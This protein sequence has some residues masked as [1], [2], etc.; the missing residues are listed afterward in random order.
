M[1]KFIF[2]KYLCVPMRFEKVDT[3]RMKSDD[4]ETSRENLLKSLKLCVQQ[5]KEELEG[6]Y[7]QPLLNNWNLVKSEARDFAI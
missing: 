7:L 2:Q 5:K 6:I 1:S 4:V 3:M